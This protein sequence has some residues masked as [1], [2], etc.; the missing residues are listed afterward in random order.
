MKQL[1]ILSALLLLAGVASADSVFTQSGAP[2]V[3]E[4]PSFLPNVKAAISIDSTA[5][6]FTILLTNMSMAETA[7]GQVLTAFLWDLPGYGGT[8]TPVSATLPA[9]S[10]LVGVDATSATDVTPEWF[11]K[12]NI[13]AGSTY[14]GPL[15]S[16][17]AG[18]MGDINLGVDTFGKWDRF[19]VDDGPPK[20]FT[21]SNLFSIDGPN[22][23]EV[24]LV[25]PNVTLYSD[26]TKIHLN[27][28]GFK[29]QGPVAQSQI[30]LTFDYTGTLTTDDFT[31]GQFLFG[32]DG[33]GVV[34]EPG[35]LVLLGAGALG[36][37]LYRRRRKS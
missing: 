35:S 1:A 27:P 26:P 22:G 11:F 14:A 21:M 29:T 19:D 30:L 3:G 25:G 31:N 6:E 17:G 2:I 28:D 5:Q 34:P 10:E 33:A 8:I 20:S 16:Y 13:S 37:A 15:G 32:T 23:I 4:D 9:G 24:G 36:L 12:D 7:I 18:V